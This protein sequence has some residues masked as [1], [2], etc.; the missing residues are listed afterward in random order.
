MRVALTDRFIAALRP[1]DKAYA[2]Y[3]ESRRI[4]G[5]GII[6]YPT[7]V[8]TW[9]LHYRFNGHRRN[10]TLGRYPVMGLADARAAGLE[11]LVELSKGRDPGTGSRMWQAAFP[12]IADFNKHGEVVELRATLE[13]LER[14]AAQGR[15]TSADRQAVLRELVKTVGVLL[16]PEVPPVRN[17]RADETSK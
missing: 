8:K 10:K 11:A 1:K 13:Q 2:V 15:L 7:G 16:E 6:V 14:L 17:R 12:K 4:P 9:T 3:D 5:F